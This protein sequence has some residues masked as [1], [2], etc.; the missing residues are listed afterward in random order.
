MFI[1][2]VLVIKLLLLSSNKK[3]DKSQTEAQ[4]KKGKLNPATRKTERENTYKTLK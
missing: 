4:E 1:V 3:F 2:R